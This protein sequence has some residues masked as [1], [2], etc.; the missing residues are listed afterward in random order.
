MKWTIL[1][2]V[3]L[4]VCRLYGQDTLYQSR[5][6]IA[7]KN[8][9]EAYTLLN[10]YSKTNKDSTTL[11]LHADLCYELE[12]YDMAANKYIELLTLLPHNFYAR[13][14]LALCCSLNGNFKTAAE[15]WEIVCKQ[16][17]TEK[18]N[19]YFLAQAQTKLSN[20]DAAIIAWSN[21]IVID[22][23]FTDALIARSKLYLKNKKYE[24][25]L[26]DIDTCL[27]V[28][29]YQDYLFNDRGLALI[30][31]KRYKEA[32]RMFEAN[33]KHNEKNVHAWFGVGMCYSAQ[34]NYLKAIDAFD[35]AIALKPDFEIAF[36]RRGLA[37]LELN[38]SVQGC[39]DLMQ[40]HSL[41]YPDALF[42]LKKYCNRD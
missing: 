41:G 11:I 31:L 36:F 12:F 24:A 15:Q 14:Q 38:K 28:L 1:C 19:W 9:Q 39:E 42:Y 35:I 17:P 37:K 18:Y 34:R 4:F 7:S 10:E 2:I 29:Q 21:A 25:A 13:K 27:K 33:I 16:Q 8:L 30:G 40:A 26:S 3:S 20:E 5:A 32:E 6:L 22:T 23:F